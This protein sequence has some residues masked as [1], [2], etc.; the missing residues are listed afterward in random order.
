MTTE[1]SGPSDHTDPAEQADP[2][3]RNE[4]P[5]QAGE[6]DQNGQPGGA[7]RRRP[8]WAVASVAA[9][10]LL[11]GGGTAYWASAASGG[12]GT[13]AAAL[14]A[15]D[16]ARAASP[17]SV[18]PSAPGI[19]P[20]E[21]DPSGSGVTY[22]A[23]APL[24]QGPATAPSFKAGGDV[25][26]AEVARLAAALGI[27]G[28]PRLS[29]ELWQAGVVADSS[30]PRLQVNLKAPGT[31]SFTRYQA[32]GSD[33]CQRGKDTCGPATLPGG[34]AQA[35]DAGRAPAPGAASGTDS[36]AGTPV[37]EEAAK[38][39]AAPVLAAAGQDGA[40][41]D[42]RQVQGSVRVVT[43][44]PVVGGLPTQGWQSTVSVGA[45]GQVVAA[46]GELKTPVR[47][48]EQPVV[49]AREA[50]DRL[51]AASGGGSGTGPGTGP[52][53]CATS[54]PLEPD[55]AV[56]PTDTLPCNPEPRPMKPPR[57]ETVRSAVL[58]LAS[59][60]VDGGRGLVP[61]WLFE[62][63]GTGGGA[64]RTVAQPAARDGGTAPGAGRTVPG[65]SYSSADRKLT[66]NFWGGACS[67]YAAQA[68]ESAEAVTVKITDTPA[69]P[70]G[71]CIMIAKDMSV[72]VT[73]EQ[74]LGARKVV[75]GTT[76]KPLA[77]Q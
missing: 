54:V 51:N 73:L 42:A 55:T 75:D 18:G 19:A 44:D 7:R 61:A 41:L 67:T 22:R 65:F 77:R 10:V 59:G 34:G 72:T 47:S 26:E 48:A 17:G 31:W 12:G 62:V 40:K 35:P 37:G 36:G 71:S 15:R 16:T 57:T 70:G 43:A 39:A 2:T 45:D 64:D 69:N 4:Q 49:G 11:A 1:Q 29:G 53:G 38:A 6:P 66:V 74:P 25:T 28:A 8:R 27:T 68:R 20:G 60:T 33:D 32:G 50:L 63:A 21:P 9:A 46:T 58:G 14:S 5:D 52:S 76:G 13:P 24:P 30:G 23:D 56:G 3:G